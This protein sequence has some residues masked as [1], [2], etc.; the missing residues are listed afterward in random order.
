M[1]P[2]QRPSSQQS[3]GGSTPHPRRRDPGGGP[4][5]APPGRRRPGSWWLLL[6]EVLER[7]KLTLR[8]VRNLRPEQIAWRLRRTLVSRGTPHVP[9]GPVALVPGAASLG[10]HWLD[11]EASAPDPHLQDRARRLMDGEVYALGRGLPLAEV[12][13][14]GEPVSQLW[15]YHLH[16]FEPLSTLHVMAREGEGAAAPRIVTLV[17]GWL[18]ATEAGRG[19]GWD[20]YPTSVRIVQWLKVLAM[21]GAGGR[22]LPEGLRHAMLRSLQR[23]ALHLARNL[24]WDLAANHLLKNLCALVWAGLLLDAPGPALRGETWLRRLA[25]EVERQVLPDG[26][27]EE[28]SPAY[29]QLVLHDLLEVRLLRVALGDPGA[30]K[31]DGILVS[32]L[33]AM[34]RMTRPDGSFLL[35]GDSANGSAPPLAR[36]WRLAAPLAHPGKGGEDGVWALPDAGFYGY[37][38][39]HHR[40]VVDC[41]PIGPRHQPAHGHCDALS[42]E[43]DIDGVPVVVDSGV[44]GYAGDPFREYSRSTRAHNTVMVDGKEQSEV[45]GLFRVARMAEVERLDGPGGAGEEGEPLFGFTGACTPYHARKLRQSGASGWRT[46]SFSSW[47]RSTGERGIGRSPSC[48]STPAGSWSRM[49]KGFGGGTASGSCISTPWGWMRWR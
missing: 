48:T 5:G 15:T 12:D 1:T 16:Y 36:I 22:L 28:R 37:T 23:Q 38:G 4:L 46:A 47:T 18:N 11:I 26:M 7:A 40:L 43:L 19:A 30:V 24:E 39:P 14:T 20:S 35:F 10:A 44:H 33:H 13:W 25:R 31:M 27:H 21:D 29:H 49:G 8:T 2:W 3:G 9:A 42:F 34:E 6:S 41:G 32:M 45:W 17:E